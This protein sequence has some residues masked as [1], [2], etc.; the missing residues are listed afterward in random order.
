MKNGGSICYI[1]ICLVICVFPFAGMVTY[2]TDTTTENRK[3]AEFPDIKQDGKWNVEFLADLGDY[4]EEHFAFRNELVAMDAAIQSQVF[5]VSNVDTVLVGEDGWLYYTD[6]L[7]DYMGLA[8]L[9]ERGAYN[10]AHNLSLMQAYVES[11]GKE[12]IFTVAPN[13][14]SLYDENMPYYVRKKSRDEKNVDLLEHQFEKMAVSYVNLFDVFENQEEVLYLKRDSHWNGKGAV[15]AYNS[16]L[17]SIE[18]EH[19][20]YE[21]NSVVR[22][23]TEYGDLNKML[24]PLWGEPEWNYAYEYESRYRY[25]TDTK[26]VE[27]PW[28]ETTNENETGSLLMFRDSFGNTLLPL[29]AEQ[30]SKGYFSKGVPYKVEEYINLYQPE[31][32]ITEIVE[33]NVSE[34]AENPPIMEAPVVEL[35]TK[36]DCMTTSTTVSLEESEFDVSYWNLSGVVSGIE[37]VVESPIYIRITAG[38]SCALYEAF[39]VTTAKS[40]Y[41]YAMYL[42]KDSA[43]ARNMVESGTCKV[44]VIVEDATGLQVVCDK[45]LSVKGY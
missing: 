8:V 18:L 41:A 30:F 1:I 43:L 26:S 5:G 6:T 7:D 31:M 2:R 11:Q 38:E 27:D 22:E 34:L 29:M 33:R 14:N 4:F 17:D 3:L 10:V 24:Y 25:V 9:S 21:G 39:T 40:D 16:I 44:E 37:P 45:V 20:R 12:F 28:I 32:V 35:D 36:M 42:K 19:E 13:K 23:K 15:L